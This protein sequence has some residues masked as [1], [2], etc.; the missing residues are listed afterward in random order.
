MAGC[1]SGSRITGQVFHL[2]IRNASLISSRACAARVKPVA[3]VLVLR[4]AASL[5]MDMVAA[6]G[7]KV[8]WATARH[9]TLHFPALQRSNWPAQTINLFIGRKLEGIFDTELVAGWIFNGVSILANR[10]AHRMDSICS[11]V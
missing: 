3:W 6:F 5:C 8:K 10:S 2:R 1:T 9:F 4:S 7:W 11:Q